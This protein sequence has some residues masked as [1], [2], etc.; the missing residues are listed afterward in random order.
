M[1]FIDVQS[2]LGIDIDKW[3]LMQSTE[4]PY[5]RAARCHAFE[6]E[7]IECAHGIGQIRARKECKIE[8]EDFHECLHRHKTDKRLKAILQQREK[9]MKDGTYTPPPCHSGK[10]DELP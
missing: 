4:Q 6:K 8:Y 9:M 7:W 2:K 3:I 1:P 10:A 5:K